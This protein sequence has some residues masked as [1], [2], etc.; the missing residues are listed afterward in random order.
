LDPKLLVTQSGLTLYR[1]A[2][3]KYAN[4]SGI[5]A[6]NDPGRWN[7]P[8]Q[9]AIYTSLNS[10]TTILER[11]VHTS[12][13]KRP[14]NLAT[15]T[16]S[17]PGEWS[18]ESSSLKHSS[19]AII[20]IFESLQM[21]EAGAWSVIRS[22]NLPLAIAV[23]SVIDPQWNI[24]LFPTSSYFWSNVKLL[25]VSPFRFDARMFPERKSAK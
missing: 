19:G 10:S 17:L 18:L 2:K 20:H 13:A 8:N 6:A 5:G 7:L 24:V 15:M 4:L 12:K 3:K 22:V 1:L 25:K 23:P 11:F 16:I 14:T 21:A 9:E